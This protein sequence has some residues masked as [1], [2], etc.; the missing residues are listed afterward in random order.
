MTWPKMPKLEG[1]PVGKVVK[2]ILKRPVLWLLKW[3]SDDVTANW[4]RKG[5]PGNGL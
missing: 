2:R 1:I 5:G 3:L 4:T